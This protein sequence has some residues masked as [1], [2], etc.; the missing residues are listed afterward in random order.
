[1]SQHDWQRWS[2]H[3]SSVRAYLRSVEWREDERAEV[4]SETALSASA[5]TPRRQ[6]DSGV[7]SFFVGFAA[8]LLRRRRKEELRERTLAGHLELVPSPPPD[9]EATFE[10]REELAQVWA[11]IASLPEAQQQM[12]RLLAID[13]LS[14]SEA[15][16]QLGIPEATARTRLFQARKN[17]DSRLGR[18]PTG[19]RTRAAHLLL[20]LALLLIG[21]AALATAVLPFVRRLTQ[22]SS[23]PQQESTPR[24]ARRGGSAT[25]ESAAPPAAESVTPAPDPSLPRAVPVPAE[26]EP[27]LA[28][29]PGAEPSDHEAAAES[30]GR[31]DIVT[32]H[33]SAEERALPRPSR[34]PSSTPSRSPMADESRE[35]PAPPLVAA[36]EEPMVTPSRDPVGARAVNPAAA[37]TRA[38]HETGPSSAAIIDAD[39]FERALAAHRGHDGHAAVAAWTAFLVTGPRGSLETEARFRRAEARTWLGDWATARGELEALLP[40]AAGTGLKEDIDRL[41][42]LEP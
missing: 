29:G 8:N 13:G 4:L 31:G 24:G 17:L 3:A 23:K 26:G 5:V 40:M 16:R 37:G 21:G 7:R 20:A 19:R 39:R 34:R 1:M 18:Q 12:L 27:T 11:A 9:P 22:T 6:D 42:A 15:A 2:T 25:K 41:L 14:P 36:S 33:A 32:V 30:H 10:Q 38:G 28:P 35:L